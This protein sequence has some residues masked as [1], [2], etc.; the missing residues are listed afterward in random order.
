MSAHVD[1]RNHAGE[2][3]LRVLVLVQG[4]ETAEWTL[5]ACRLVSEWTGANVRV[6]GLADVTSPPFT[7]VIPPARRL[8]AAARAAWIDAEEQRVQQIV[9]RV[10]STWSRPIDV[11][12]DR[13]L[14]SGRADAIAEHAAGW[15]ADVVVVAEPPVVAPLVLREVG[16]A[17]LAIP[18]AAPPRS[19]G[20]RLG[21]RW[22][23]ASRLRW[24][25][26]HPAE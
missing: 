21:L 2:V 9:D 8:Y 19:R 15:G 22:A 17:V 10:V 26:A 11:V 13:A 25:T 20:R 12:R 6:L 18:A 16:C 14:A 5:R 1:D 7:S 3:P 23:V 24:A 4:R